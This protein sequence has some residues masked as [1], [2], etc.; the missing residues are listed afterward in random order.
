M[1]DVF[2]TADEHYGHR[3]II[4]Y[5]GRPFAHVDEMTET[6]IA[7]HNA[8]VPNS[9]NYL[10][11]HVGDWFWRTLSL[12]EALTILGRLHGRHAFI[13]GNHDE[14]IEKH[15][16]VFAQQLD[17]I[18]GENKDSGTHRLKFNGHDITLCHYAMRV[19]NSSHKGSWMVYGHSHNELPV[20]GK[21]FDIGVDG[22]NFSPWSLEEIEK[23]MATLQQG[24]LITKLPGKDVEMT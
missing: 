23:K 10:T 2:I 24:H 4:E 16:D 14:L 6:I 9:P 7:R 11:I 8:K 12:G 15:Q 3:R 13:F 19:W 20:V 17:W 1:S 21:S 5:C 18:K 22:H